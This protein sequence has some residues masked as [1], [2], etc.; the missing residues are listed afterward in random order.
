MSKWNTITLI[1]MALGTSLLANVSLAG[2]LGL[3]IVGIIVL[4]I[5]SQMQASQEKGK[6]TKH[7]PMIW[8]VILDM[9]FAL[10]ILFL[11]FVKII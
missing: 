6:F 2:A 10:L 7:N 11:I 9:F 3:Y 5:I 1:L 8:T 4:I